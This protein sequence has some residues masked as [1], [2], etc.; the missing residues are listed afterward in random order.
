MQPLR[1]LLVVHCGNK[2]AAGVNAHHGPGREVGYGDAGLADELLGLVILVDAAENYAVFPATIVEGELEQLLALFNGLA[3]LDLDGAEIR[4]AEGLKV[5]EIGKERLYLDLGEV[6]DL[7]SLGCQGRG[8]ST[9]NLFLGLGHVQ[10][11]HG[12][13]YY[14]GII[15]TSHK[16]L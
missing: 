3:G 4:A 14:P 13:E 7:I 15:I 16:F 5:H 10:R 9:L 8:G 12:G 11:L 1:S 2:H 6:Y